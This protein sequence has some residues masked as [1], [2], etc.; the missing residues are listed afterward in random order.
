MMKKIKK[1]R[2]AKRG[3]NSQLYNQLRELKQA[4]SNLQSELRNVKTEKRNLTNENKRLQGSLT[5]VH[6]KAYSKNQLDSNIRK[7]VKH[8]KDVVLALEGK[9]SILKTNKHQ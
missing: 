1:Q 7:Q 2:R 3:K 5:R 6:G 4:L 9:I 8:L